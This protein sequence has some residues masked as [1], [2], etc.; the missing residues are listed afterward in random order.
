MNSSFNSTLCNKTAVANKTTV[1]MGEG[2]T[3]AEYA[4]IFSCLGILALFIVVANMFVI[5]LVQKH[6][7][8]QTAT[9]F[10]L[11]SLACSDFLAGFLVIPLVISSALTGNSY[12]GLYLASDLSSRFICLST[13]LHLSCIAL[14]RYILIV[15]RMSTELM[16]KR[17]ILIVLPCIWLF[18]LTVTLI[19]LLW[20]DFDHP[21]LHPKANIRHA[22]V[23]YNLCNIFI[24]VF[25]PLVIIIYAYVR[26]Y[27]IVRRQHHSVSQQEAQIDENASK[28]KKRLKKEIRAIFIYVGMVLT[29]IFGWFYYFIGGLMMDLEIQGSWYSQVPAWLDV[30]LMF[31][32]F[33]TSF[34]NPVLYTFFKMDFLKAVRAFKRRIRFYPKT[35]KEHAQGASEALGMKILRDGKPLESTNGN[36]LGSRVETSFTVVL[37][38]RY[39]NRSLD[40]LE[41]LFKEN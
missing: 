2:L 22:E 11:A 3:N 18:T 26:I 38:H 1:Q 20:I 30:I 21:E 5:Y 40:L 34:V 29:Y 4:V 14:E 19:Q 15:H 32:R 24:L 8:L 37:P 25:L 9:N 27:I 36:P 16:S 13:I 39:S 12:R 33:A 7:Y 28:R 17:S 10:S 41:S 31:I 23:I 6:A 35:W